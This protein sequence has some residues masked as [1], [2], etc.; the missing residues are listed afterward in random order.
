MEVMADTRILIVDDDRTIAYL[1]RHLLER[2]GY[3]VFVTNQ[4]VEA[5]ERLAAQPFDLLLTDIRMPVMDGFELIGR[6]KAIYPGIAV[7]V[8]TGFASIENALQALHRGVDGLILKPFENTNEVVQAVQRVLEESCQKRDAA[9][10]QALRPLFDV[11]ERLLAE[12]SPEPLEKLI[13]QSLNDL[14]SAC[15]AG[16]YYAPSI[17]ATLCVVRTAA[18]CMSTD[19]ETLVNDC[20]AGVALDG[21]PKILKCDPSDALHTPELSAVTGIET[22]LV[23]PVLHSEGRI[24][25]AAGRGAGGAPFSEADV[26][27]IVILARQAAVAMENA[28][29]YSDLKAT[30][31]RVE[32]SQRAL[33]QAEKMA[34]VG[35][36]VASLAHE[37]N[38][39]LQSVRNCLHLAMRPTM[40]EA[41]RLGYIEMTDREVERLVKIVRQMLDF[42]RPGAI[43][44]GNASLSQMIEQ[45]LALIGPQLREQGIRLRVGN[46]GEEKNVYVV[47][48]QIKQVILNVLLNA[49]DA[50]ADVEGAKEKS[51]WIDIC[52]EGPRVRVLIEDSGPGVSPEMRARIFEPF[53]STKQNGTGLGL[54]ISYGI[55]EKHRGT[56][57]LTA[58]RYGAGAC[59]EVTLPVETEG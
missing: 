14:F 11:T 10:L 28:R 15:F 30:L 42:Y 45:V 17:S 21:M 35:R 27:M 57:M 52:Y 7:L 56:L 49:L 24:V 40:E 47:A 3:E 37:I 33:I 54:A 12:T 29:L 50:F 34:A 41:Q 18:P 48:D 2:A 5:L 20:I 22:M 1:C 6:A 9:R 53:T 58:P 43:E 55:L 23:A 59:F 4:P 46:H 38:N 19:A 25:L 16:I 39:P 51:I 32:E 26:E 8:M 31:R 36:L 44:R 13:L